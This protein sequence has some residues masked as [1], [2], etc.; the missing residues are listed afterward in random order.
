LE[1]IAVGSE[2]PITRKL[3]KDAGWTYIQMLNNPVSKK[4]NAGVRYLE[5][6]APDAAI[7]LGS[8]DFISD[9][10]ILA[11][12]ELIAQDY[13][14]IGVKDMFILDIDSKRFGRWVGYLPGADTK[15][16]G[17]TIGMARCISR[18]VLEMVGY[19]IWGPVEIDSGLDGVMSERFKQLQLNYCS[20]ITAQIHQVN[21]DP[22]LYKWGHVGY[23][24]H[25][26]GA[27]GIDIKTSTNITKLD[28]YLQFNPE[29]MQW[30]ED[31]EGF[32]SKHLPYLDFNKIM[33]SDEK[34]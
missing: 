3:A 22:K 19:D 32:F 20:P 24:L 27:V 10:L 29:C 25:E 31:I 1:L 7:I 14:L 34:T 15:R 2:G 21:E 30:I 33:E 16:V 4:W 8:D 5:R 6:V 17:E 28:T 18:K 9:N 13:V 23:Y 26:L 12:K 11:Y